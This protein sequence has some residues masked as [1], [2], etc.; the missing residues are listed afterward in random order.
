MDK[1]KNILLIDDDKVTNF[2]NKSFIDALEISEQVLTFQNGLEAINFFKDP[3]K[4]IKVDLVFLDLNMPAMNG[5]QFMKEYHQI[6]QHNVNTVFVAF[7][8][9]NTE[10]PAEEIAAELGV[11][12]Y[13]SKP[14]TI[15]KITSICKKHF[16]LSLIK[17]D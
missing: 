10:R 13:I 5:F 15:E 4:E 12:E 17:K 11:Q 14:I 8:S 2:I 7:I 16:N 1:L 3:E 6:E 9:E